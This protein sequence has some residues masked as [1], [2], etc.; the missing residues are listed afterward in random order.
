MLF[1]EEVGE[2]PYR[3]DRMV[4]QL[5]QS[6]LLA[7]ASAVVIGELPKCDEPSGVPKARAVIAELFS[8]FPRSWSSWA[9]RPGHTARPAITLPFGVSCRVIADNRPRLVIEESAVEWH[10][11]MTRVH[12]IGICGT[13]MATVAAMLRH[14]GFDVRAPTR[15]STRR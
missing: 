15:T 12:F 1:F 2:R 7:R 13:A 14:K 4:T 3:L 6:G 9:S 5:Q 10:T 8:D 11:V